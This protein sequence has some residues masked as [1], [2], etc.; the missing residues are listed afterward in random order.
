[1]P[2]IHHHI[3]FANR[4]LQPLRFRVGRGTE[5]GD[6][7]EHG[8][9]RSVGHGLSAKV[10]GTGS[11][12]ARHIVYGAAANGQRPEVVVYHVH[13][14]LQGVRRRPRVHRSVHVRLSPAGHRRGGTQTVPDHRARYG[15][16]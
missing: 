8:H 9:W 14:R 5:H 12:A 4:R 3:P 10:D 6:S 13:V 16:R 7:V 1:L 2:A 15:H 11:D